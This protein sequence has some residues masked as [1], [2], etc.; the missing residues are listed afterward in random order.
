M[1]NLA[2]YVHIF[3]PLDLSQSESIEFKSSDSFHF[4]LNF[5]KL[6]FYLFSAEKF[7]T[8]MYLVF[9]IEKIPF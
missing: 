4:L 8:I 6:I 9:L 2:S 5:S 7:M 1:Y 3:Y